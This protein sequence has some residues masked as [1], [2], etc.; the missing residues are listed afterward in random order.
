MV[1]SHPLADHD[2]VLLHV[3]LLTLI[4]SLTGLILL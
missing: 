2:F 1:H 4:V 3:L